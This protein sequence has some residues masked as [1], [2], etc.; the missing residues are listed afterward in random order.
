MERE[1]VAHCFSLP[2]RHNQPVH[3]DLAVAL[4]ANLSHL[5]IYL[6]LPEKGHPEKS[7]DLLSSAFG[8]RENPTDE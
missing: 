5:H 3:Y 4:A 2:D 7:D 1:A 8:R 6:A